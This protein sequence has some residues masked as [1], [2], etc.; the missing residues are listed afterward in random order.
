MA[1]GVGGGG[2]RKEE[3]EKAMET[4]E[5]IKAENKTRGRDRRGKKRVSKVWRKTRGREEEGGPP[6]LP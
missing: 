6:R 4:E 2:S 5:E 1:R 3:E